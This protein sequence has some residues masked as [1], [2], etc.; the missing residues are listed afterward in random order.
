M[1]GF[2]IL[3]LRNLYIIGTFNVN[4]TSHENHKNCLLHHHTFSRQAGWLDIK[5]FSE[6]KPLEPAGR[7][8]R[9]F[10]RLAICTASQRKVLT[11]LKESGGFLT[12]RFLQRSSRKVV[13]PVVETPAFHERVQLWG[14]LETSSQRWL[15]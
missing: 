14:P 6:E 11:N 9:V 7:R 13:K 8:G 4:D 2:S 5:G 12:G 1:K 10:G 3:T 15:N